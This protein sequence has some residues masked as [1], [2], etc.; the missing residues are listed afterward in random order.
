[1]RLFPAERFEDFVAR[2]W[3]SA[4]DTFDSLLELHCADRHAALAL[5]DAPNRESFTQGRPRR[6]TWAEVGTAV[7]GLATAL[8]RAGIR[9]DDVVGVQL[10]N[11]AEL[12]LTYLACFRIGAIASPFP[13][14]YRAHEVVAMGNIGGFSAI[15]T[16]ARVAGRDNAVALD[17]L[18]ADIP[19]LRAVLA[20]GAP[21]PDGVVQLDS[22]LD[23]P[24]L[25]EL[26]AVHRASRVVHPN[27]CITLCWTSGTESAPK[28]VP[29]A[30]CDW[31]AIA[32]NTA[33]APELDETS[34]LL[35]TFPM[36]N[37]GGLGGMFTPWLVTGCRLVMHH[38][39]HLDTFL[40]QV[41]AEGVTHSVSPPA[42]LT[43][44]LQDE[45]R[46]A[47][48]DLSTLR[49]IGSGS[50]TM[51]PSMIEGWEQ[52]GVGIISFFGSNEGLSLTGGRENI[53]DPALR[54]FLL[55]RPGDHGLPTK[56]RLDHAVSE[57]L[58][59]VE[60]GEDITE[61][62]RPGELRLK[63][64]WIFA[65]YWG[66]VPNPFD[67]QGYFCTGDVFEYT[68][69]RLQYVRFLGR[70]KDLI[71]RGGFKI[72]PADIEGIVEHHPKVLE[73]AALG[74][75]DDRLGERVCIFV[76]PVPGQTPTLE[77]IVEF[78]R[79]H[80]VAKFKLP[81]RL[82]LLEAMPRSAIGK[83]LKRDLRDRLAAEPA[84][85]GR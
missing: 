85:R 12:A 24:D 71:V 61:G 58:V 57:R 26:L 27:D 53:P 35:C 73:V 6:M 67:E 59:D 2:G 69:D 3:W 79:A 68:G 19:T 55:P 51:L 50:T 39:F 9:A 60:T 74:A 66:G 38:P 54:G 22:A 75:P 8:L 20:F 28:G 33:A 32:D 34:V 17:A 84:D 49:T 16:A 62:E 7:D 64:P 44:L 81:E 25:P 31:I 36:V 82:E 80:Q 11:V 15:V 14:Q 56:V 47:A 77:E 70:S 1:M 46:L 10:P 4:G 45:Q 37:A 23:G 72:S 30:H 41:E 63:G 43:S 42:V 5:V 78:M 76:V 65:G 83:S 48:T 13:A 52:R 29:R 18:R 21:L 40:A